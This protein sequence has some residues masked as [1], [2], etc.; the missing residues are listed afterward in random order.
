MKLRDYQQECIDILDRKGQGKW[1]VQMSTGLG[2]TVT[3]ANMKRRGRMLIL[4]HREELVKQPLKYFDCST[5]IEMADERSNGEDVVSASVQSLV[6]RLNRFNKTD[7]D[8]IVVDEAHHAAAPTYRKILEY[9]EPRQIVG[10]T[11]TPNRGDKVRLNDVFDEIVF[12]RGLRWGIENKYLCDIDCKRV[13]IGYDLS[14]VHTR[15]GDFA[16]DELAK[17]M[18]GTEKAIA[19][20]YNKYAKGATLIF[21]SSVRHAENIA[22]YIQG[23]VV[24]KAQTNNRAAIIEDFTNKKIP[25]IV[26]CMIFTEGT[27]L[28]LVE[29]VI[30]ARPT[31]SD[32]LYAQMVG[33]GLRLYNGKKQLRLIDCVGVTGKKT[34]CT[35]PSLLGLDISAL[36]KRKRDKVEGDLLGLEKVINQLIDTPRVWIKS[37]EDVKLWSAEQGY[38]LRGVNYC[39]MPDGSFVCNLPN[40]KKIRI[41]CPDVMGNVTS[42]KTGR[43]IPIQEAFDR[44]RQMLEEKH[45]DSR[46]IW[47]SFAMRRWACDSATDKQIMIIKKKCRNYLDEIDFNTLTKIQASQIIARISYESEVKSK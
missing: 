12:E 2:K 33:R 31:Q 34:L 1:L 35:A 30:I 43:T 45:K 10:F 29:T 26:N 23:A 7:F 19:E 36:D 16:Q 9:F 18:D 47:D 5:G 28:P 44:A 24:V 22:K 17:Q 38:N 20:V 4:S 21:A 14:S 15:Q 32:S 40:N 42:S 6:R 25:C 41:P 27:D 8:T 39:R 11:A 37:I 3:F 13:D 46:N